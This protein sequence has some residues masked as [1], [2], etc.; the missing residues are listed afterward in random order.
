LVRCYDPGIVTLLD[1]FGLKF[2]AIS[3]PVDYHGIRTPYFGE[4]SKIE[5]KYQTR[6]GTMK[7]SNRD[8]KGFANNIVS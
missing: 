2:D 8:T 3:D 6:P 7:I 5:Q 1:K 4:I